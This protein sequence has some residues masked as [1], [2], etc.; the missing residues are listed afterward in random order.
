[1]GGMVLDAGEPLDHHGDPVQGPQ[2]TGEPVGGGTLQQRLLD[3][4]SW[5]SDSRG[6]AGRS[7]ATSASVPP[8]PPAGMPDA[9]GLG[10]DTEL[11]GDL[12]LANTDGE[13]LGGTQPAGL[14][15]LAFLVVPQG[16]GRW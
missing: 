14:E 15:P 8:V 3:L 6:G 7:S 16:G 9:D 12:G 10:G 4:A 2:F 5:G 11:A 13:Q 1:M